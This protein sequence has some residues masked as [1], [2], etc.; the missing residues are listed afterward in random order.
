MQKDNDNGRKHH[1]G[2][3]GSVRY[4]NYGDIASYHKSQKVQEKIRVEL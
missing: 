2:L 4:D 3:E 1:N